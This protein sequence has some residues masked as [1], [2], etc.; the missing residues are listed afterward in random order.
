MKYVGFGVLAVA[1]CVAGYFGLFALHK[2][3]SMRSANINNQVFHNTQA[4][5]DGK[6]MTIDKLR[7][8]YE[9]ASGSDRSILRTQIKREAATVDAN[10]LPED[11]RRFLETL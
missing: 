2:D 3:S 4:F 7:R 11:T 8:E 10:L 5:T 9:R 6:A 1:A